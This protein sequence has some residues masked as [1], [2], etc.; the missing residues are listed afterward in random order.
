MRGLAGLLIVC[1]TF[2]AIH[3]LD[4]ETCNTALTNLCAQSTTDVLDLAACDTG[5]LGECSSGSLDCIAQGLTCH[6]IKESSPEVCGDGLDNDCDGVVDNGCPCDNP[7]AALECAPM[8]TFTDDFTRADNEPGDSMGA[9]YV[10]VHPTP[11]P[12]SWIHIDDNQACSSNFEPLI[13]PI[14]QGARVI[15]DADITAHNTDGFQTLLA[16]VPPPSREVGNCVPRSVFVGSSGGDYPVPL[17]TGDSNSLYVPVTSEGAISMTVDTVY[18]YH[19]EFTETGTVSLSVSDSEGN[20]LASVFQDYGFP[21][22]WIGAGVIVG[23]TNGITCVDNLEINV[24]PCNNPFDALECEPMSSFTDDFARAD[25]E[26]GDSMGA[27]YVPVHPAPPAESWVHVNNSQACSAN[28]EPLIVPI[29]QGARVVIDADITAYNTDGFQALLAVVPAL[30]RDIGPCAPRS[31]FAGSNGGDYPV[32]FG[33]GD[34]NS[35]YTPVFAAES[36]S[37]TVGTTYHYHAEFTESGVI[38]FTVSDSENNMLA[39][40]TSD[41]G[42]PLEWIGAGVIVGR[43]N[44][45]TCVDNLEIN[46]IPCNDPFAALECEPMSTFTDDFTRADNEP[47]DSMGACYVPVHPT[48]PPESWIHIDDNQACSSNFEPLIVPIVQGARV[49]IDADITAHNADGFQ[50]LLAIVPP[51]SRD[52]GPCTPRSI[53]VGSNGGDYPVPLGTG[54]SMGMNPY[55]LSEGTISMAVDTLYHYHAEF[56]ATGTMS[57]TVSDS[58]DNVLATVSQDLGFALEWVGAGV[59]VGRTNGITCVDNLS[60]VVESV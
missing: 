17:R 40:V 16:I 22:E 49:I 19:A 10:P 13:V 9:C 2:V 34:S 38:T 4:A 31:I 5:L 48:P 32:T 51:L 24:V 11:P 6:Q 12:E 53:Y 43:T 45:I 7:F 42:F 55:V 20:V 15:I 21:L 44:G 23:R 25:N 28:F 57:L 41:L 39:T 35:L 14:V 46:V 56:T 3:A 54:D 60:I 37:M 8:S 59:I 36:V 18:H 26:P 29:V 1:A 52:I 30:S 50:T 47:G 27:C 33:T 58:E